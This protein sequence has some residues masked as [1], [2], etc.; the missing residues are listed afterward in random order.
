MTVPEVAAKL[1]VS[2]VT[3]R[4][5]IQSGELEALRLG[6]SGSAHYRVEQDA[7]ERF[8]QPAAGRHP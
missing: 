8:L 2:P 4:R 1:A 5:W 3:V 7:V 6:R